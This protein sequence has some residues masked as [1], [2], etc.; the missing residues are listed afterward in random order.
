MSPLIQ[1][2]PIAM[3]PTQAGCA[4]FLGDGKKTILMYIDPAVGAAIN[5]FLSGHQSARPMTH[6]LYHFTLQAFGAKEGDAAATAAAQARIAEVKNLGEAI[7]VINASPESEV[8]KQGKIMSLFR[9]AILPATGALV[10][11]P[12]GAP[13]SL[14]GYI[15]GGLGATLKKNYSSSSEIAAERAGAPKVMPEGAGGQGVKAFGLPYPV[16]P[17]R[18]NIS[19]IM[20]PDEKPNYQ[21]PPTGLI[22]ILTL[23]FRINLRP[24]Q[25][26]GGVNLY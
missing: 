4:A 26:V 10:G 15:L 12:H 17:G 24:L 23:V 6:D 14:V 18:R 16:F 13:T 1:V 19:A 2:E 3:L 11:L 20:P 7:R 21:S 5:V 8:I 9:N 25:I 22:R